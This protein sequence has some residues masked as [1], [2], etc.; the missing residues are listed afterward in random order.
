MLDEFFL[1]WVSLLFLGWFARS[2]SSPN[3]IVGRSSLSWPRSAVCPK[4]APAKANEEEKYPRS[5]FSNIFIFHVICYKFLCCSSVSLLLFFLL[6]SSRFSAAAVALFSTSHLCCC[7]RCS[8]FHFTGAKFFRKTALFGIVDRIKSR[9]TKKWTREK[10]KT[11]ERTTT[12]MT[13]AITDEGSLRS[14]W[15]DARKW[16]EGIP[17]RWIQDD[18]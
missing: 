15:W 7:C 5:C 16:G 11:V 3:I 2:L 12:S 13:V 9:F 17:A 10:G 4:M 8:S 6:L 14:H 1:V 18:G